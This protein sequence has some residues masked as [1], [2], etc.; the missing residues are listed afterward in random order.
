LLSMP[1]GAKLELKV[2]TRRGE[3]LLPGA[4]LCVSRNSAKGHPA[5]GGAIA[6]TKKIWKNQKKHWRRSKSYT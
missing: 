5:V 3:S 2:K 1:A 4:P 6:K